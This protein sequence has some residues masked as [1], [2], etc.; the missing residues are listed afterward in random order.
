MLKH[1]WKQQKLDTYNTTVTVLDSNFVKV[2][3]HSNY[4]YVAWVEQILVV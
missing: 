4:M 1:H 2:F 3:L